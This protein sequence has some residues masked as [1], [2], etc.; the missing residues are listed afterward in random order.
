M[1]KA[2]VF[3]LLFAVVF[4][5]LLVPSQAE[6]TTDSEPEQLSLTV[7]EL[8]LKSNPIEG[9][10][11]PGWPIPAQ[12]IPHHK[13]G[14]PSRSGNTTH[15][16]TR[17]NADGVKEKVE[18]TGLDALLADGTMRDPF[19]GNY[20]LARLDKL[21]FSS[22]NYGSPNDFTL[23]S[24]E[25]VT[26]T[27]EL[28]PGSAEHYGNVRFN[29][30]AAGDLNGDYVDEQIAA[31]VD[32]ANQH[33]MMSIGEL[34]GSY[35]KATSA[36]AVV[37]HSDGS[38][39]VVVRGYDQA[40]WHQ[41]YD[42]TTWK[43]WNNT[44]GGLLL[45]S[46]AITSRAL[47]ELD[48]FAVGTDNHVYHTHWL[49]PTWTTW[50][51]V[52]DGGIFEEIDVSVPLPEAYSP[53][54]AARGGNHLDLF[55]LGPDH[56]L[57]WSHSSDGTTWDPWQNLGG[58]LASNP[59]AISLGDG[60]MQV[61]ALGMDG[62]LWYR[63]YNSGWGAWEY[64]KNPDE[65]SENAFPVLTS[66]AV[67]E[68][69]VYLAG[70]DDQI[71]LIEHNGSS[72]G[73]WSSIQV[74]T[75]VGN[76]STLGNLGLG[77]VFDGR[78]DHIEVT[79]DVSEN[80][81]GSSF[82]F[83][84]TCQDCG[85]FSVVDLS[86]PA[87]Y[88]DRNIELDA[89]NVCARIWDEQIICTNGTNYADGN[90]HHVV[91]T[92]GSTISG[93]KLYL[94]GVES[95]SGDKSSSDEPGQTG[96]WI[97]Y[98]VHAT[99]DY[100]NGL[101]D[102][103]AV[104]SRTLTI[105]DVQEIYTS[106]WVSLA[107][108]QM[109]LHLEENPV[110]TGT[111][112][113]D[114]SGNG[115]DGTLISQEPTGSLGLEAGIGVAAGPSNTHLFAQMSDGSLQYKLNLP[116]WARL[117]GLDTSKTEFDTGLVTKLLPGDLEVENSIFDMTTGHFSGD[118]RQQVV[119]AYEDLDDNLRLE[120][121]DMSNGFVL[122]RTAEMTQTVSAG[123]WPRVAAGDVDGDGVDEIGFV[124]VLDSASAP[125]KI[126]LRVFQIDKDINNEWTGFL[127]EISYKEVQIDNGGDIWSGWPFG[128]TLQI[129]AG[130][131]IPEQDSNNDEFVVISDWR[132]DISGVS[133][134]LQ[135][136]VH[137]Y[138]HQPG[139]G[140]FS[141]ELHLDPVID[142]NDDVYWNEIN[143]TGVGLAVGNVADFPDVSGPADHKYHAYD[144]IVVTW[145]FD[146]ANEDYPDMRR[147]LRVYQ[148][149]YDMQSE[150][151]R[152][153]SHWYVN[154][155]E[156]SRFTFLDTL[157]V[158][159]LDQ[160]LKDEIVM[161]SH[162]YRGNHAGQWYYLDVY[163][164]DT[165]DSGPL[166]R[167]ALSYNSTP[168]AFNLALGDFTGESLRV[169]PPTYRVQNQMTSPEVFLNL[170]PMHRDII[171]GVGEIEIYN[172]ASAVHSAANSQT[173][174]STS[175]SKRDWTLSAG[176]D[177]SV[178]ASGHTLSASL[179]NTYGENFSDSTTHINEIAFADTTTA[180]LYD[181]VI[182]NST[183]YAV[184]E[185]PVIGTQEGD[186]DNQHA[187]SVV[188]P[189]VDETN[190]PA[191]RQGKW[192]DENFYAPSH[193]PYN[194]WSYDSIGSVLFADLETEIA[195]KQTSG[196]TQFTLEMN[197][198][199][200]QGLS[201]SFHNQISAG[202][203][204]S[205]ESELSIP[206]VGKAFDFSFRAY[207]NG[208]Y[209]HENISTLST[210]FTEFSSVA[211][212]FP[213]SPDT[214]AYDI[215][216]YLY[217][218]NAGYLV[219]DYQSQPAPAG[220]WLL[221]TDPDPAFI[222]PWYGFP[223]PVSGIFPSPPSPDAPPCGVDKQLF[224]HD[225]KLDPAYVQNGETVTMT[226]TVR[227]FSNVNPPSD[228]AVSFYLGD[229]AGGTNIGSCTIPR[230]NLD[231]D[232]GPQQCYTTWVVSDASGE[233]KVYAV[234]DPAN[235]F[236]EMHDGDN[237][238]NNNVGYGLLYVAGADYFDPGLRGAQVYQEILYEDVPGLGFGLYLPTANI[239]ETVRY[240]LVPTALG[241]M[242]IVGDPIQV[243]AF[244]GGEQDPEDG[245]TFSPIPAGMM[246]YYRDSDLLP[247]MVEDGL[248]LFR[249]VGSGWVE[250]TCPGYEVVRFPEDN[251]IA[252]PIC[253]TGTFVL[254]D[255]L[256]PPPDYDIYLPLVTH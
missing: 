80:S 13:P 23:E 253:Q 172:G 79:V 90:W 4:S 117:E 43:N 70:M 113:Y 91:H 2:M 73:S 160:D 89:G 173:D 207:V 40:L 137:L 169:G 237:V 161:A 210:E 131:I 153:L 31:W 6:G 106:G 84:T 62:A 53:A 158:G 147:D 226:A 255:E 123:G 139:P 159:D 208:S 129:E 154:N 180:D 104:F 142:A 119:L 12:P 244:R 59:G 32:P 192:C 206:L 179:D 217:W 103:V 97:G 181:Q 165:L 184:W 133:R 14:Q 82:W 5:P 171:A 108:L 57:R 174:S 151:L 50:A 8:A 115:H 72:W 78:D 95:A 130:D 122:T 60:R 56:T 227:N 190:Q 100:F 189:L 16:V 215:K 197:E 246:A 48:V 3:T 83:K 15:Q 49:S 242:T 128:G 183:D 211:V 19:Q 37:A 74:A 254:T 247:G 21:M 205:Y 219:V 238:I 249:Q 214:S 68:V 98:S 209:G 65:F 221:Y 92:H 135:M 86:N 182:Y 204:Y 127:Q 216:A 11:M 55:R 77:L 143:A 195:N 22:Y 45:S 229:P 202:M 168:R 241:D 9:G 85:L 111:I 10:G 67:G 36:P 166:N 24:L 223:D 102:E 224:T 69:A 191:T 234:I 27:L 114:S 198:N 170:P 150:D 222:L 124:T 116:G 138:D 58:M 194:V 178:G 29:A 110:I 200:Q 243:L 81:Y 164:F 96:L 41:H 218:A 228:V 157:A 20:Q 71:W 193:Q 212:D 125:R 155:Q 87:G 35:G 1:K 162:Y 99:S 39:D 33:I 76:K 203:E 54:V 250:A 176:M 28:I 187:I 236:S 25:F 175:V 196:G 148:Y 75:E 186:Q 26:P 199:N 163:E 121:Y 107:G 188:F 64:L 230:L 233:E 132:H 252:V 235:I 239:T 66:P 88:H 42:G 141:E 61:Y 52:E 94:D 152:L 146:F 105:T 248:I 63:T 44:A 232:L 149:P 231:R 118:G 136:F 220:S 251:H 140:V 245:H 17:L 167:Y 30:I 185:Y 47:G 201:A 120:V 34:P 38:L 126:V 213:S 46:P 145:P 225:I 18:L 109:G 240:E 134:Q 177:M 144:E 51:L 93:Q 156:W 112:L 101:I 7:N 256:L